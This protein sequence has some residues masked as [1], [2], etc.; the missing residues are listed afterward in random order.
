M[1]TT[2]YLA[3]FY[4]PF[5]RQ[6]PISLTMNNSECDINLRLVCNSYVL[7]E[8]MLGPY[9]TEILEN[10]QQAQY[11]E[12]KSK[13]FSERVERRGSWLLKFETFHVQE[14]QGATPRSLGDYRQLI[15][16]G[17]RHCWRSPTK[18]RTRCLR[19]LSL[20]WER[21]IH[22]VIVCWAL[23][24]GFFCSDHHVMVN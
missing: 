23:V 7:T 10:L 21:N 3:I 19:R 12:Y 11:L 4:K 1:K 17:W 15:S 6:L 8:V 22:E 5:Y 9:H 16:V 24:M 2:Q 18:S 14:L 20:L 13:K